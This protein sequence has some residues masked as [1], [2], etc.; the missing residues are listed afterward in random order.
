VILQMARFVVTEATVDLIDAGAD[1]A[2]RIGTLVGSTLVARKL[3]PLRRVLVASQ[4]Y[5]E[6][7]SLPRVTS[8]RKSGNVVRKS[9]MCAMTWWL[10]NTTG[11]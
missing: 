5:A 6:K 10:P 11:C 7:H 9:C 8:R 1:V 2:V 4:G 3:A